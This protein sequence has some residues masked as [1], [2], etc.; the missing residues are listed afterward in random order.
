MTLKKR[1]RLFLIVMLL[2]S[3]CGIGGFSYYFYYI[4]NIPDNI[5]VYRG[6]EELLDFLPGSFFLPVEGELCSISDTDEHKTETDPYKQNLQQNAMD[7]SITVSQ[8]AGTKKLSSDLLHINLNKSVSIEA[9]KKGT[10]EM[11]LRCLGVRMKNVTLQVLEEQE[12]IPCGGIVGIYGQTDGILVLGTGKITDIYGKKREPAY[13]IV[14][15]GDYITAVG[16]Q[17]VSTKEELLEILSAHDGS[18]MVL[19]LRRD[20]K[21]MSVRLSPVETDDGWRLGIWVRSD[22]QGIGTMTFATK[23]GNFGALGHAITDIDI[24][25]I[26]A[27]S[28]AG[29]YQAETAS[30]Q[31]GRAGEPGEL[32]GIIHLNDSYK[33]GNILENTYQGIYGNLYT[34][35][36]DNLK[37]QSV[38][39]ALKQDITTG[40]ATIYCQ[41]DGAINPYEA[42][43]EKIDKNP[44]TTSKSM[45]IHITDKK[46]LKKT[47]GIIQ[48]MSGSPILQNG[49]FVGAVTHVF[50]NDPT[51]GYGILA[52]HM[53]AHL[54]N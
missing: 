1:Y 14:H 2:F 30:I 5:C 8:Y 29:L 16:D 39:A 28:D 53:I 6:R 49:A 42:E 22:T 20:N 46:L 47:G 24:G 11:E 25:E 18:E 41:L 3:L 13:R 21:S 51:R 48:G 9:A 54:Q 36:P 31:K 10:Y 40:K 50:V 17:S 52:E 23:D 12:V 7:E 32:S 44:D 4:S 37:S 45:V 27:L 15:S 35:L 43:I 26:L 19:S 34:E 33:L 38:K